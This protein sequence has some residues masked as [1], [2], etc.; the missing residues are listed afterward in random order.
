MPILSNRCSTLD[1]DM[2]ELRR[3]M[4]WEAPRHQE[5][6]C[7]RCC[8]DRVASNCLMHLASTRSPVYTRIKREPTPS[9]RKERKEEDREDER[10]E[11]EGGGGWEG[12]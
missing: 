10:E 9:Q 2:Q 6:R 4:T 3:I 8:L 7:H 5:K 12:G 11:R 1:L